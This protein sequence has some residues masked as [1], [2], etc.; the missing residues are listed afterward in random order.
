MK[1]DWNDPSGYSKACVCMALVVI[2]MTISL[3]WFIA[4]TWVD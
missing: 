3:A 2:A 1:I 4:G